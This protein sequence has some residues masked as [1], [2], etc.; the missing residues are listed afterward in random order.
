M[1]LDNEVVIVN[2][3]IMVLWLSAVTIEDL[4]F[5]HATHA[6]TLF[7]GFGFPEQN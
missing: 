5:A 2:K 4:T 6:L 3:S 7:R 1:L